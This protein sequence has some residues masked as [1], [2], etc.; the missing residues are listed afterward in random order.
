VLGARTCAGVIEAG[1][2]DG[3]HQH[4]SCLLLGLHNDIIVRVTQLE[5]FNVQQCAKKDKGKRISN[6]EK[7]DNKK[8]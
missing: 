5:S 4:H 6:N 2:G 8:R 1:G 3:V 7:W